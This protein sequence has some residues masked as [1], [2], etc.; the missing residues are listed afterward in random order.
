MN[1]GKIF[2]ASTSIVACIALSIHA[3]AIG[4]VATQSVSPTIPP[5][6]I[7]AGHLYDRIAVVGASASDGFGVS[8]RADAP[9]VDLTAPVDPNAKQ[10]VAKKPTPVQLNLSDV[11]RYAATSQRVI[12]HHYS[13]G[14]FFANPGPTGQGEIYRALKIKPTLVL[15]LDFL[16]W[17]VYGTVTADGK[18]MTTGADRFSN[19]ELGLEQLDRIVSAGI[20][21]VI[22]D[23]ADMHDAIGKML[24]ENQVPDIDTIEKVNA[25]IMEWVKARPLVK[26]MPLAQILETLK[27]GGSIDLAGKSWNPAEL[28]ALLQDDQLHPT[29]AG[30][31]VIAAGLIDLAKSN[32]PS[33]PPPFDFDPKL[34]RERVLEKA[35]TK[36]EVKAESKTT[37]ESPATH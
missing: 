13:S 15:G 32:D 36:K 34:I 19:L 31:V 5:A 37:E 35:A 30:T 1:L 7:V 33:T 11:L 2:L 18:P 21:L 10:T 22:A 28:G 6:P 16:F 4:D 27:K 3:R 23:I 12:M 8:V 20:P 26:I 14:F 9:S 24:S 17:Y 25:R 29:F